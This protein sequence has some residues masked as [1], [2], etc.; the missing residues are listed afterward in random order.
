MRKMSVATVSWYCCS[1]ASAETAATE[2]ATRIAEKIVMVPAHARDDT[3]TRCVSQAMRGRSAQLFER[4]AVDAF[5]SMA[6]LQSSVS[7]KRPSLPCNT[8]MKKK[9]GENRSNRF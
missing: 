7:R 2:A 8:A 3:L 6:V 9:G 1:A 4:R 5:E